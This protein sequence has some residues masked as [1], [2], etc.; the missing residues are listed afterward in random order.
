M[1]ITTSFSKLACSGFSIYEHQ[2]PHLLFI[3][4]LFNKLIFFGNFV[5]LSSLHFCFITDLFYFIKFSLSSSMWTAKK[6]KKGKKVS[7]YK[8]NHFDILNLFTF[9]FLLL[10]PIFN[11]RNIDTYIF[12]LQ[13]GWRRH[14]IIIRTIFGIIIHQASQWRASLTTNLNYYQTLKCWMQ[15]WILALL[16]IY[17]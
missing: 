4:L 6:K 9:F 13:I 1:Q 8:S 16:P 10:F 3:R 14:E 12:F 15:A 11:Q 2:N 17:I 5:S 7:I